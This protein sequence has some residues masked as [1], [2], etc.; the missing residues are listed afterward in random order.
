[1]RCSSAAREKDVLVRGLEVEE[2]RRLPVPQIDGI[3]SVKSRDRGSTKQR[4]DHH[5][6]RRV[7]AARELNAVALTMTVPQKVRGAPIRS[8]KNAKLDIPRRHR[9]LA[10]SAVIDR[11]IG[12]SHVFNFDLPHDSA[13]VHPPGR[14]DRTCGT[15][16]AK[17]YLFTNDPAT[18]NY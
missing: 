11:A 16:T 13:I 17:R 1:V 18:V 12:F 6:C 4:R 10:A 9:T 8:M 15:R 3:Q 14:A 5:G 7:D 2:D